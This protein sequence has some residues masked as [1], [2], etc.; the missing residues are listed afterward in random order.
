MIHAQALTKTYG[1]KTVVDQ[2]DFTVQPGIVT[3]FL[4]PN[5]AGKSTTMRMILGLDRPSS[6]L[7]TVN[8]K[9]YVD[10][11]APLREVGALLE[12]RSVH[13]GRSAYNHLLS[14]A[15]THGIST[16]R[17]QQVIDLVGLTEVARKGPVHSRWAWASGW[18]RLRAAGRPRD[19]DPRRTGERSGPRRD[20]VDPHAAPQPGRRR[21]HRPG[22]QSPDER[23]GIDGRASHRHREGAADRRPA[24]RG[25]DR[26]VVPGQRRG[27]HPAV[28]RAAAGGDHCRR[29][30][31]PPDGCWRSPG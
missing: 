23:N 3:G 4:G 16:A 30:C 7:V 29:R 22:I 25:T 8:G 26:L 14:L 13:T 17:V 10:L 15:R 19:A 5:G 28:R 31:R 18:N 11:P 2:L 6:G 1:M 12:A 27:A 9:L 20:P 24:D 21:P